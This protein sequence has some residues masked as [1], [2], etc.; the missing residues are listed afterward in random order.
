MDDGA[1]SEW[2]GRNDDRPGRKLTQTELAE[3]LRPF[4]IRP[5]TIWA[6]NRVPGDKSSRGY[7]RSAFEKVWRAHCPPADTPTQPSKHKELLRA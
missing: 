7:M 1:W 2:R 4:G 3:L 5:K 6:R